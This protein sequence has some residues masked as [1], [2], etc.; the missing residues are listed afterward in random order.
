MRASVRDISL[1]FDIIREGRSFIVYCPAL[2]LATHGNSIAE[3]KK[4]FFEAAELFFETIVENDTF[5]ETLNNL[6]WQIRGK[7]FN[8]PLII[9]RD[10][11]S[12][13]VPLP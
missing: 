10:T 3:A 8:P 11:Q 2:D 1:Q 4:S 12:I 13:A 5:E 6:G 9:S 7:N